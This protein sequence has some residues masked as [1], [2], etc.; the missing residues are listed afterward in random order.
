MDDSFRSSSRRILKWECTAVELIAEQV[1]GRELSE[2]LARIAAE[3]YSFHNQLR[4]YRSDS[5][6]H[7]GSTLEPINSASVEAAEEMG[8]PGGNENERAA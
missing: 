6:V 4:E 2:K 3:L 5:F 8:V 1:S 7:P